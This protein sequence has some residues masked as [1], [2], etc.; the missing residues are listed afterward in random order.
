MDGRLPVL[1]GGPGGASGAPPAIDQGIVDTVAARHRVAVDEGA[2]LLD[3]SV[4]RSETPVRTGR[5]WLLY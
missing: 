5:P 4:P 1:D 2:V 3:R